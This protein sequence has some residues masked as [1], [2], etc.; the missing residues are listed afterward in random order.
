MTSSPTLI[1]RFAKYEVPISLENI[2]AARKRL[3]QVALRTPLV[4]LN[5]EEAAA[6]IYL[7]LEN[8]QPAGSFK[9]RGAGNALLLAKPEELRKG[10][11]TASAG[12]MALALAWQAHGMGVPCTA[13]VPDDAPLAKLDPLKRLGAEIIKVPFADYQQI[14]R[15]HRYAGMSGMLIHPF[16]DPAVMA[17]NGVIGL[18]ILEDLPELETVIIPY[19]GGGLSCGIASALR[20]LKPEVRILAAEADTAAP[21][22]ASMAAGRPVQ[23]TYAPSFISGIGA[24]FVFEEMWSMANAMLDGVVVVSLEEVRQAMRIMG[25]RNHVIS[26]GAGAVAT[27]SA[28]SGKAGKGKMACIVSGGNIDP[29]IFAKILQ[30]EAG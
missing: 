8:L 16:A 3:R 25:E 12:N 2:Q 14:Q 17:G 11:W 9:L 6:D 29:A 5:V 19:G 30:S 23:V 18:E 24:P 10:V 26:E 21:L 7:K 13:I 4:R 20:A 22:S 1:R 15:E 28:L 27:A